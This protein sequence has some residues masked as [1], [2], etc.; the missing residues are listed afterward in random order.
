[1]YPLIALMITLFPC[2]DVRRVRIAEVYVVSFVRPASLAR[3]IASA[4]PATCNLLKIV[5]TWLR[6]V[7]G[8][9]TRRSAIAGL[10]YP[11]ASRVRTSRSRSVNSG[12]RGVFCGFLRDV[13]K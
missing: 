9:G 1:M 4:R 10:V 11:W 12:K 3:T 2:N 6:T 7:L 5:E 8:L 13:S